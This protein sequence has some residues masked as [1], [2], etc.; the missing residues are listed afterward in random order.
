MLFL[1][2]NLKFSAYF[3]YFVV[4]FFA[5]TKASIHLRKWFSIGMERS[6]KI[7]DPLTKESITYILKDG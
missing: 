1:Y 4:G 6:M 5:E 7:T 3:A 2:L